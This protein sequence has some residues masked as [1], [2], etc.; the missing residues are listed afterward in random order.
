[1]NGMDSSPAGLVGTAWP[2]LGLAVARL[3]E[4]DP[5][6][7][8][9]SRQTR[10]TV[11]SEPRLS[12]LESARLA[13]GI[14]NLTLH[15]GGTSDLAVVPLDAPEP[16]LILGRA[17]LAG[18]AASRFRVGR[19]L[20]LLR[21]QAAVLDRMTAGALEEVIRAG[22]LLAG[23]PIPAG[24]DPAMLKARSKALAKTMSRKDL[25]ALDTLKTRFSSETTDA[26]AWR[27]GVLRGADRFGL[28]LAGDLAVALRTIIGA[29]SMEPDELRR[30]DCLDLV[31]F[32]LGD[33]FP[34]L[35]RE[36]GILLASDQGA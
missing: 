2:H 29:A 20:F 7:I 24:A 3:E 14:E 1:M 18:D 10:V 6:A 32:A 5:A 34:M 9:A 22:A 26:P 4:I 27:A 33:G 13:L 8:G 30:S 36:A 19:A 31:R 35:R 11:A 12:W 25:K 21:H 28:L 17:I 15:V 23:A 16:R